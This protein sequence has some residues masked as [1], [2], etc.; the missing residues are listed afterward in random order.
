M[1]TSTSRRSPHPIARAA[2][3]NGR[4]RSE[5]IIPRVIRAYTIQ[6]VITITRIR[7]WNP[8]PSA[9]STNSASNSP[10]MLI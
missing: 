8:G 7:F 6:R 10:G 4:S 3:T 5:S 1:C 2:S 9:N